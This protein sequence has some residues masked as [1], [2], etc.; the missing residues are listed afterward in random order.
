[1]D[2]CAKFGADRPTG[3]AVMAYRN[4]ELTRSPKWVLLFHSSSRADSPIELKLGIKL[5]W[6]AMDFQKNFEA[7]PARRLGSMRLNRTRVVV[8]V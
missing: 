2:Y 1:M 6:T 7:D 4:L 5:Q 8:A 3:S